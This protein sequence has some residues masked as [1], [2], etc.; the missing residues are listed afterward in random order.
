MKQVQ[1]LDKT[2]TTYITKVEIDERVNAIAKDLNLKYADKK[3][4]FIAVLNGAF[5]FASEIFAQFEHPAEISFVKVASYHGTESSGELKTLIGLNNT[6]QGRDLIIIED[7]ID[8]G[9]TFHE[10]LPT[11]HAQNPASVAIVSLLV[12]PEALKYPVTADYVGFEIPN[13][14]VVGYGLDYDGYGRNL[15]EIYQIVAE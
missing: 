1:V 13:K 3:P 2:F 4:M 7:I 8:T 5:L 10:L 15:P 6:I 14:F 9:K 11:I 12:K